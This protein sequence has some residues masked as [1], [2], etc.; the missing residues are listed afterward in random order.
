MTLAIVGAGAIASTHVTTLMAAGDRVAT[1]LDPSE[2]RATALAERRDA[3]VAGTLEE[4]DDVDAVIVASSTLSHLS[5]AEALAERGMPLLLE[6]PPWVPGQQP[7]TL[8]TTPTLVFV[9]VTTR[10]RIGLRTLRTAIHDG[11]LGDISSIT[12]T[13]A[14]QLTPG[15]LAPWY[16][17]PMEEGGGVLLTNGVHS[18]DRLAWL[19]GKPLSLESAAFGYFPEGGD[20]LADLTFSAGATRARSTLV[21]SEE[22]VVAS[23]LEVT[24]SLGTARIA[25]DGSLVITTDTTTTAPADDGFARQWSVFTSSLTTGA[26][27]DAALTEIPTPRQ[28]QPTMDLIVA[29]IG[30]HDENPRL[31]RANP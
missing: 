4:L 9:G 14:Y 29:A 8:L 20:N 15:S 7:T 13:I 22:P 25:A 23:T 1:V 16:R 30:R 27:T 5:I 18:L 19:L 31:R 28:L 12:D 2:E 10:F 17:T 21:W 3:R 6:K 26:L 24:G 11:V